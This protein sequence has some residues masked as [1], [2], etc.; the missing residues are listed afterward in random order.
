V[1][2]DSP[3]SLP[4]VLVP[5]LNC[6]ARLYAE[7][8]PALWRFGPVMVADH[9]RDATIPAIASRILAA[10]LPFFALIGLSMGGYIG[11][12]EAFNMKL[13]EEKDVPVLYHNAYNVDARKLQLF[14]NKD[15][16]LV[17]RTAL[18]HT[19]TASP[20]TLTNSRRLI[21]LSRGSGQ[22]IIRPTLARW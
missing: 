17:R 10:A 19:T 2:I 8:I 15:H 11:R 13:L 22:G 7:Q 14:S 9:T 1:P 16:R 3:D 20:S 12:R 21:A 5:G 4:I 18:G 6:S